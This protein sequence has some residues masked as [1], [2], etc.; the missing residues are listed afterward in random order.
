MT[1]AHELKQAVSK[2]PLEERQELLEAIEHSI[3]DEIDRLVA[4]DIKA[5]EQKLAEAPFTPEQVR[6][7]TA[8]LESVERGDAS[9]VPFDEAWQAILSSFHRRVK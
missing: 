6:Q 3:A 7:L 9:Y 5:V 4:D 2:L 8:R 1:T